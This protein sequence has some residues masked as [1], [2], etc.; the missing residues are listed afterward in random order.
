MDTVRALP[1]VLKS[2][3]RNKGNSAG[4][5]SLVTLII[6]NR[7]IIRLML[8]YAFPNVKIVQS[9]LNAE[10]RLRMN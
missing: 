1:V 3:C 8:I 6:S 7:L 10:F 2:E 4:R 9:T 5:N